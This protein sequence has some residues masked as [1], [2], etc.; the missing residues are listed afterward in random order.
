MGL[1]RAISSKP[2]FRKGRVALLGARAGGMVRKSV[3]RSVGNRNT[4]HLILG[5]SMGTPLAFLNKRSGD[6]RML[7]RCRSVAAYAFALDCKFRCKSAV[8]EVN[9]A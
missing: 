8:S 9:R 2:R 3:G 6:N 1:W 5:F 7:G 4:K